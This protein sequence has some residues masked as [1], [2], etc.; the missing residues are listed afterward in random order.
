MDDRKSSP[1]LATAVNRLLDDPELCR[2]LG[3]AG[4]RHVLERYDWDTVASGY[5]D[6]LHGLSA[7][8]D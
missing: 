3:E 5:S 7:P 6:L 8:R 2:R 4:R 1:A